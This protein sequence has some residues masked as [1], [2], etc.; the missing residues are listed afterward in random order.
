[1]ATFPAEY[2]RCESI[3]AVSKIPITLSGHCGFLGVRSATGHKRTEGKASQSSRSP[4]TVG[5]T[6]GCVTGKIHAT[7][8]K[9]RVCP[10]SILVNIAAD[11]PKASIWRPPRLQLFPGYTA[12]GQLLRQFFLLLRVIHFRSHDYSISPLAA[13]LIFSRR[14]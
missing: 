12:F 10:P 8:N 13:I 1:M 9:C 3:L 5:M 2:T 4:K 11:L 6:F 14:G 7:L